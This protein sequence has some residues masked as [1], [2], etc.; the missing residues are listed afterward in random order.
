MEFLREVN[1]KG[2]SDIFSLYMNICMGMN[3]WLYECIHVYER[4]NVYVDMN[5]YCMT[6]VCVRMHDDYYLNII[7]WMN[8]WKWVYVCLNEWLDA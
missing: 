5:E 6:Y 8:E 3:G 2:E 1:H 7:V 4:T